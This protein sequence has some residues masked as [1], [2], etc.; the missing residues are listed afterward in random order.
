MRVKVITDCISDISKDVA[1]MY[2]IEVLSID[3]LLGESYIHSKDLEVQE[4]VTYMNK[5]QVSPEIRGV[6]TEV[7]AKVFDKYIKQGMEI[8]CITA[9][10]TFVSNYS[11]CLSRIH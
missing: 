6:N 5:R 3:F 10:D 7:Y 4:L 8:I 2:D 11:C 1:E 9:G